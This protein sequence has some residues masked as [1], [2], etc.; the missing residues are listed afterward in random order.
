VNEPRRK[1]GPPL[2]K[3]GPAR[4]DDSVPWHPSGAAGAQLRRRETA[5]RPRRPEGSSTLSGDR[6]TLAAVRSLL[7]PATGRDGGLDLRPPLRPTK[8]VCAQ[9]RRMDDFTHPGTQAPTHANTRTCVRARIHT[10][11][12]THTPTPTHTHIRAR[13]CTRTHKYMHTFTLSLSPRGPHLSE[14]L[15]RL[16]R[17]AIAWPPR[18]L[19]GVTRGVTHKMIGPL[20]CFTPK[21]ILTHFPRLK[22]KK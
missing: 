20:S 13:A 2:G 17:P 15:R 8:L 21:K 9:T 3:K 10:H 18:A 1:V 22:E 14:G 11:T 4:G 16:H 5:A 12:L 6:A 19:G 7:L